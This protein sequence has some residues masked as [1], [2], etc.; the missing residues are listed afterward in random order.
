MVECICREMSM[1][2]L[3]RV[4]IKHWSCQSKREQFE[5]IRH[6]QD[7]LAGSEN[8]SLYGPGAAVSEKLTAVGCSWVGVHNSNPLPWCCQLHF[9]LK[10]RVKSILH[11]NL[12][13]GTM[14][15]ILI[16]W[17]HRFPRM[18]KIWQARAFCPS[19][20]GVSHCSL[21]VLALRALRVAGSMTKSLRKSLLPLQTFPFCKTWV[22]ENFSLIIHTLWYLQPDVPHGRSRGEESRRC[23]SI[24]WALNLKEALKLGSMLPCQAISSHS[25]GVHC[26]NAANSAKTCSHHIAWAWR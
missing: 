8:V 11:D 15:H 5:D 7:L 10:D 25:I 19:R 3:T 20:S 4:L 14:N 23:H 6:F 24:L 22:H 17:D 12:P 16:A 21:R 18:L 26:S 9:H 2:W 13:L 1:T